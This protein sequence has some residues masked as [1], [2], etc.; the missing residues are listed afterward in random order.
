M[1]IV[2]IAPT[3]SFSVS[4]FDLEQ[5]QQPIVSHLLMFCVHGINPTQHVSK[6]LFICQIGDCDFGVTVELSHRV[7]L[8]GSLA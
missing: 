5:E 2:C 6:L 1:C 7:S 8:S 3:F 4:S